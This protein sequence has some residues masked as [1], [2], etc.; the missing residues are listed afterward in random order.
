MLNLSLSS[1]PMSQ[2]IVITL[3]LCR[4]PSISC[5]KTWRNNICT[6]RAGS[7]GNSF[8]YCVCSSFTSIFERRPCGGES[9]QASTL[10]HSVP[11]FLS[12]CYI[13]V[14]RYPL[15]VLNMNWVDKWRYRKCL[16]WG[17][18]APETTNTISYDLRTLFH[19]D[20]KFVTSL[21]GLFLYTL[22]EKW[23]KL[24]T[25]SMYTKFNTDCYQVCWIRKWEYPNLV[26]GKDGK[27]CDLANS[28]ALPPK[29]LCH[30][31]LYN[32]KDSF[33]RLVYLLALGAIAIRPNL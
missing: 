17:F 6:W 14:K 19:S 28:A 23:C 26:N 30:S 21:N 27:G 1:K 33:T 31:L 9:W 5:S 11:V 32:S 2:W 16:K 12:A 22:N 10:V 8:W 25:K 3:C 18:M 20:I 29:L 4:W 7:S 15:K 13:Q 24:L